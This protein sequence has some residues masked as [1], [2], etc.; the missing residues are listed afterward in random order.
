MFR[1]GPGVWWNHTSWG[2]TPLCLCRS[3][4]A[5][6]H[7]NHQKGK[8]TWFLG[9]S[10]GLLFWSE[11][12]K[13][14]LFLRAWLL[15]LPPSSSTPPFILSD[16]LFHLSSVFVSLHVVSCC[17]LFLVRCLSSLLLH[18]FS[19]GAEIAAPWANPVFTWFDLLAMS[20]QLNCCVLPIGC[21][22]PSNLLQGIRRLDFIMCQLLHGNFPYACS[23]LIGK[24]KLNHSGITMD[25]G[26]NFCNSAS[27][28][29]EEHDCLGEAVPSGMSHFLETV[30]S[31]GCPGTQSAVTLEQSCFLQSALQSQ[32]CVLFWGVLHG[33]KCGNFGYP[34][35]F[36]F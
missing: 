13:R 8:V 14:D 11:V 5:Q 24:W 22:Y 2:K 25:K 34:S 36:H 19:L 35:H 4:C 28:L 30:F 27:L 20:R 21:G 3:N 31:G 18:I 23:S 15:L 10:W 6:N 33:R 26:G 7:D 16:F 32:A 29:R 1:Y 9:E 12:F 17:L